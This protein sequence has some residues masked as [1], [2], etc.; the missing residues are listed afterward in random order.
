MR[1]T[2]N[3]KNYNEDELLDLMK[4]N[5]SV[6][7]INA[8]FVEDIELYVN[9]QNEY[10]KHFVRNKIIRILRCTSIKVDVKEELRQDQ[11]IHDNHE[12]N[13]HRGINEMYEH[14]KKSYYFPNMKNK[15]LLYV[16]QCEICQ[17]EKYE[18]KP[19]KIQL[20]ITQIPKYP[21]EIIHIDIF[22]FKK[23]NQF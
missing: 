15:I 11:I 22:L 17:T 13:N 14:I 7:Q 20:E 5:F 2:I 8:I 6:T 1:T 3:I 21:L 16:N 19:P 18:R 23:E 9:I 4:N 10:K 12:E